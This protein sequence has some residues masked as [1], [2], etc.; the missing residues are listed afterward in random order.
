MDVDCVF[1]GPLRELTETKETT[2]SVAP[3]TTVGDLVEALVA[4]HE[5]LD[6]RLL[7]GSGEIRDDVNVT[8]NKRNVRQ[9]DGVSTVLSDGDTVRFSPSI[10]GG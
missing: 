1:F 2:R 4:D 6:D 10:Q 9:L 7:A 8:V 5:G 3:G